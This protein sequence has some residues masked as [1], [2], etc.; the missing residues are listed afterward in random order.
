M[1]EKSTI[2]KDKKVLIVDHLLGDSI[3]TGLSKILRDSGYIPFGACD[4]FETMQLLDKSEYV[5]AVIN[6]NP[7]DPRTND[8]MEKVQKEFPVI[9]FSSIDPSRLTTYYRID[10]GTHYL[11]YVPRNLDNLEKLEELIKQIF[12]QKPTA[13]F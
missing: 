12:Q 8:L 2:T 9:A 10:R 1:D 5:V 13:K 11:S 6:P 4:H 7:D 3:S